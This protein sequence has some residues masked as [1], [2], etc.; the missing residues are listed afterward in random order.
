MLIAP[1]VHAIDELAYA[2]F[3]IRYDQGLSYLFAG[4]GAYSQP[5]AVQALSPSARITVAEL[6]PMVTLT[7]AEHLYLDPEGMRVRHLDARLVLAQ[8]PGPFDLVVGDVFHDVAIPFHLVTREFA[9]L[10]K[11]KLSPGGLYAMNVVDAFPDP[12]LIKALVKTLREEFAFVDVWME[13]MPEH[14]RVTFVLTASDGPRL[15]ETVTARLGFER[16][17]HRVTE[18]LMEIG[19]TPD[20]L[21]LLT[22][23]FAPVERLIAGLLLGKDD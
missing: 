22:D 9:A 7:A 13:G 12:R 10:V 8:E 21:P 4:G 20:A 5:R 17:W 15:P 18:M 11:A 23:D 19:T 1:Y 14:P 16:A 6:D 3:G 2:H